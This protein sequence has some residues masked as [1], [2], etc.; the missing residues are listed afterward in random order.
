MTSPSWR[1]AQTIA[2]DPLSNGVIHPG[3][4]LPRDRNMNDAQV[5]ELRGGN[6][7]LSL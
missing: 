3:Q 1:S 4:P 5:N 6:F 2:F 7:N